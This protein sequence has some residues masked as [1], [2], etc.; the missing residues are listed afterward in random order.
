MVA[1]EEHRCSCTGC[2][3]LFVSSVP[4]FQFKVRWGVISLKNSR[5]LPVLGYFKDG[6]LSGKR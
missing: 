3:S 4:S 5:G 6:A 1:L 2:L